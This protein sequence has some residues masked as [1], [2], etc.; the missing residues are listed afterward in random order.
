MFLDYRKAVKNRPL[1]SIAHNPAV[2]EYFNKSAPNGTKYVPG[3]DGTIILTGDDSM[4]I[5]G[6]RVSLS[7]EQKLV[8]GDNPQI[9]DVMEY[10]DNSQEPIDLEPVKD[11]IIIINGEEIAVDKITLSPFSDVIY[12]HGEFQLVPNPIQPFEIEVLGNGITKRVRMRRVPVK[13]IT[14]REFETID[15]GI[16]KLS[17][18]IDSNSKSF[19][20]SYSFDMKLAS[21]AKEIF[22]TYNFIYG[23]SIGNGK[24]GVVKLKDVA[25]TSEDIEYYKSLVEVW[26]K[27]ALIEERLNISLVPQENGVLN[28]ETYLVELLYQS[29]INKQPIK[30]DWDINNIEVDKN[31]ADLNTLNKLKGGLYFFSFNDSEEIALIGIKLTI[32][33]IAYSTGLTI[34]DID[35]MGDKYKISFKKDKSTSYG[36]LYFA[37]ED[38]RNNFIKNM[39]PKDIIQNTKSIDEFLPKVSN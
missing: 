25:C 9:S 36:V 20:F 3:E 18:A 27:I 11:G 7:A 2:I 8:L 39:S 22:E 10:L 6:L 31:A 4:H 35:D 28:I 29:L 32:P 37:S 13:S 1:K 19:E 38:E 16:L 33:R 15:D 24:I 17:Y 30:K 34:T 26:R 14:R 12:Q 23:I 21:S 5:G